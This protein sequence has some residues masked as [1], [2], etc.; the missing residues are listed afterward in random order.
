MMM[1]TTF[2]GLLAAFT[3]GITSA[4]DFVET[5]NHCIRGHNHVEH[6]GVGWWWCRQR[7]LENRWCRSFDWRDVNFEQIKNCALQK[8]TKSEVGG[9]FEW[10]GNTGDGWSYYERQYDVPSGYSHQYGWCIEE[11]SDGKGGTSH[12]AKLSGKTLNQCAEAC[13]NNVWCK[14]FD[15]KDKSHDSGKNNC[16]IMRKTGSETPSNK[17]Y[18]CGIWEYFQRKELPKRSTDVPDGFE[19]TADKC[20]RNHVIAKFNNLELEECSR[21]CR[22]DFNCASFD[23]R[24]R[25]G[26]NCSLQDNV[27][28]NTDFFEDCGHD[29]W[30]YYERVFE[31]HERTY[32]KEYRGSCIRGHN[33][34]EFWNITPKQC[35]Q[36]CEEDWQCKN[37]E[38]RFGW[39][40]RNCVTQHVTKKEVA[41]D[42]SCGLWSHF[43]R[44]H[45]RADTWFRTPIGNRKLSDDNSLKC[46]HSDEV[47]K[48][49]CEH[50]YGDACLYS[51]PT[52]WGSCGRDAVDYHRANPQLS[53]KGLP[54]T[55]SCSELKN[56][57]WCL[58]DIKIDSEGFEYAPLWMQSNCAKT[59]GHCNTSCVLA[60]DKLS[61]QDCVIKRKE[62][63]CKGNRGTFMKDNCAGTC[64]FCR[65]EIECQVFPNADKW[66]G[67][68]NS[69]DTSTCGEAEAV[70]NICSRNSNNDNTWWKTNCSSEDHRTKEHKDTFACRT[71]KGQFDT[72]YGPQSASQCTWTCGICGSCDASNCKKDEVFIKSECKNGHS[73]CV[74]LG[75]V[76]RIE[77]DDFHV[78]KIDDIV[79]NYCSAGMMD[80]IESATQTAHAAPITF[81]LEKSKATRDT[82]ETQT[83]WSSEN[84]WN[85]EKFDE[86]ITGWEDTTEVLVKDP[87]TSDNIGLGVEVKE[88]GLNFEHGTS[89]SCT[90]QNTH[91]C[92]NSPYQITGFP[93]PNPRRDA[94][95]AK[96]EN[97]CKCVET[98]K[99]RT[100][101]FSSTTA[102]TVGKLRN[103][104]KSG[105]NTFTRETETYT[106][107]SASVE[108]PEYSDCLFRQYTLTQFCAIPYWG[109]CKVIYENKNPT[110]DK[111]FTKTVTIKRNDA[112]NQFQTLKSAKFSWTQFTVS[113]QV[114]SGD[115]CGVQLTPAVD[116]SNSVRHKTHLTCPPAKDISDLPHC[117]CMLPR[118]KN[119]GHCKTSSHP[120][121]V[122]KIGEACQLGNRPLLA[123]YDANRACL[124]SRPLWAQIGNCFNAHVYFVGGF[125]DKIY[126][127]L[128]EG[129]R[130]KL[131][132]PPTPKWTYVKDV[133]GACRT[134]SQPCLHVNDRETCLRSVD[135]RS[136]FEGQ[137]CVWCPN[138]ACHGDQPWRCEPEAWLRQHHP[139]AVFEKNSCEAG[140]GSLMMDKDHTTHWNPKGQPHAFNKWYAVFDSLSAA[141]VVTGFRIMNFG[142]GIHDAVKC[143]LEYSNDPT[144]GF[145]QASSFDLFTSSLRWQ[146]FSNS[147]TNAARYWKLVVTGTASG[148][149]PWI[150]E[151]EFSTRNAGGFDHAASKTTRRLSI[152][153]VPSRLLLAEAE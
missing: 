10:C 34:K 19:K 138:G 70:Q 79:A 139:A 2:I 114:S 60:E 80:T 143:H 6:R 81:S 53:H 112:K 28:R 78:P 98:T 137:R 38:Y 135:N 105:S 116:N 39:T 111:K 33:A 74:K 102:T 25:H 64:G 122:L 152:Q 89:N 108:C 153:D 65:A 57:G 63:G 106:V 1:K 140:D 46:P 43:E 44:E 42:N 117:D 110:D 115:S 18:R 27:R 48:G 32:Y 35:R 136:G 144:T 97:A 119:E 17:F 146:M 71:F 3:L 16:T 61:R 67:I 21:K 132:E 13:N 58:K 36:K 94:L 124:D 47:D 88:V 15:W 151:I 147:V 129:I 37:F 125:N 40:G 23:W 141:T 126:R 45:S 150:R 128:W 29:G 123:N 101:T 50:G 96:D 62:H 91:T 9:A 72:T 99:S 118:F 66:D 85:F 120:S 90:N 133:S 84:E 134:Q 92:K 83:A 49:C 77:C 75:K 20:M 41:L 30:S 14:A 76:E 52:L 82:R 11:H 100:D 93:M 149:Q 86:E 73:G 8:T 127:E 56:L 55:K 104:S 131:P 26:Y 109:T 113:G 142:D 24:N 5:K 145:K 95:I 12:I 87:E 4:D 7:C 107:T 68:K 121:D 103:E 31:K 54:T 51:S 59:C 22:F 69:D 148:Q 130:G